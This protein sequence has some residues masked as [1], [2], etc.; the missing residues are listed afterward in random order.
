[1]QVNSVIYSQL[2]CPA[3]VNAKALLLSKGYAVEERKIGD[4]WT[5]KQLLDAVPNARS[6]PQVF[7]ADE[8]IGGLK[9]LQE[10]LLK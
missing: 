10:F 3:C 8:Y 4:G 6:V 1:M 2:N 7:I 5:K 9:E